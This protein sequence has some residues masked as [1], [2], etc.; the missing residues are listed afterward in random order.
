[1]AIVNNILTEIGDTIIIQANIP[2]TG[3]NAITGYIDSVLNETGTRFFKREF[4]Y[5]LDTINWTVWQ[6][7]N[8]PNLVSIPVDPTFDFMI[9]YR[10]TRDGTDASGTLVFENVDLQGLYTPQDC[11]ITFHSSVFSYFFDSCNSLPVLQWC[12]SVL[13]K[14]Y[15]PG[16]VS[17]TLLR[18]ENQNANEE[19]RDYIDFWRAV[20]CY[21]GTL[22]AYARE[23]ETFPTNRYLLIEYLKQRGMFVCDNMALVDLNYL[24]ENFYDEIRH[25]GTAQI[26][27]PKGTD[28]NGDPKPVDGELLRLICYDPD[29]DEFIFAVSEFD[30][31]GWV[32]NSWSPL[33][34]GTAHQDQLTKIY[35]PTQ[36]FVDLNNYPLINAGNCSIINDPLIGDVMSISAVPAGATAGI[37]VVDPTIPTATD[38]EFMTNINTSLTYELSFYVRMVDPATPLSVRFYG[39]DV[40]ETPK[41]IRDVKVSP[42]M[43][44]SNDALVEEL[45]TLTGEYYHVRVIVHPADHLYDPTPSVSTPDIGVGNN[46]KVTDL[47]CKILP[48]IVLDNTNGGGAS[49]ELR[50]WGMKFAPALTPYSTGFIGA[51]NFVQTWIENNNGAY[52]NEQITTNMLRYLLPY[53]ATLQNN[54]I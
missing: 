38:I 28:V 8:I 52:T 16:L 50:I 47:V 12:I 10:Y 41:Q 3:L 19:D 14:I 48:E 27:I 33:Y 29:C 22:V 42:L 5:S 20:C 45:M 2:I 30:S 37:G 34:Q 31:I 46:L 17:K 24:M 43:P 49:G 54:F 23:F 6:D 15:K 13:E 32:V 25:R 4:R 18:D 7:L 44:V 9:E 1:M 21:F 35:E 39:Y 53:R 26:A 51:S 36:D 11:S 40:N